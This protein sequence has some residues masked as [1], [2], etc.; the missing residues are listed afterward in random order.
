MVS[1]QSLQM[2]SN[3]DLVS[4]F[5]T[6]PVL[7]PQ[8]TIFLISFFHPFL[9]SFK[10]ANSHISRM[11]LLSQEQ[12]WWRQSPTQQ[13]SQQW[14][15]GWE[16]QEG[17]WGDR[18]IQEIVGPQQTRGWEKTGQSSLRCTRLKFQRGSEL[19]LD[20]VDL[21]L[22]HWPFPRFK[23]SLF[24]VLVRFLFWN[25]IGLQPN[26]TTKLGPFS[27]IFR[28]KNWCV[29]SPLFEACV[30]TLFIS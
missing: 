25:K 23:L 21:M 14:R 24:W 16:R 11:P 8:L 6:N 15:K 28:V 26:V 17:S 1:K 30:F 29:L 18:G 20:N 7:S 3:G 27:L 19:E 2:V 22:F 13:Q 5:V 10:K 12:K 9:L 4:K